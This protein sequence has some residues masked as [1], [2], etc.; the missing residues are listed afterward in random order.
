MRWPPKRSAP[1]F[2]GRKGEAAEVDQQAK[3]DRPPAYSND[4]TVVHAP[5]VG[6]AWERL[7]A[8]P[9]QRAIDA[10]VDLYDGRTR[11]GGIYPA[12]S[13]FETVTNDGEQVG[14][15]FPTV[16]AAAAALRKYTVAT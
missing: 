5:F 6:P 7:G 3:H 14:A 4:R 16:T 15:D 9:A 8:G 2:P 10:M 12:G 13:R 1:P 11:L